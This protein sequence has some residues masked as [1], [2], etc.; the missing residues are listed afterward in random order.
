MAGFKSQHYLSCNRYQQKSQL[1]S[2]QLPTISFCWKLWH[3]LQMTGI[4][5]FRYS[6]YRK[7]VATSFLGFHLLLCSGS[8][9]PRLCP[10][11]R[12]MTRQQISASILSGRSLLP[13]LIS[14]LRQQPPS[15]YK[16][17]PI[18]FLSFKDEFLTITTYF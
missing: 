5:F 9:I 7:F 4:Q 3:L 8:G 10:L 1:R 13:G 18:Q 12:P 15:K 17:Y 6:L 16:S 11:A 2:F 14:A